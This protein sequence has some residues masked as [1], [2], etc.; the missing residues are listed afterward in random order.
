MKSFAQLAKAAYNAWH[1]S[2]GTDRHQVP[3]EKLDASY[4]AH[5]IA[6]AKAIAQEITAL[7]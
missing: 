1:K 5:W 3:F 2:H 6:V 4:R 7:H